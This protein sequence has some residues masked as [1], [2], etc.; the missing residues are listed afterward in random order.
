MLSANCVSDTYIST[1]RPNNLLEQSTFSE[2]SEKWPTIT[3]V[4]HWE[5]TRSYGTRLDIKTLHQLLSYQ[6]TYTKEYIQNEN[7]CALQDNSTIFKTNYMQ[8]NLHNYY[9]SMY[10]S[11]NRYKYISIIKYIQNTS[12]SNEYICI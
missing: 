4:T 6:Y 3:P 7:T 10:I 5:H 12:K 11:T 2:N 9:Q 8:I 1:Y